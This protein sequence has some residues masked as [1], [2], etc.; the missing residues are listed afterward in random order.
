[1]LFV[2]L[3]YSA[4]MPQSLFLGA[5]ALFIHFLF[6]KF[7]LL[8]MWRQSPD[9]GPVLARLSR[10]V[11]FSTSLAVHVVM[12][13]YWWSGYPYDNVCAG[14]FVIFPPVLQLHVLHLPCS[15]RQW[16]L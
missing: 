16:R 11:F 15:G 7:C 13:A 4:L 3:F 8:R 1:M 10:N 14:K 12:S 2:A 6:G 5:L 9:I